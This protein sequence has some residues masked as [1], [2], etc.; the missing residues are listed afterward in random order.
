MSAFFA[1]LDPVFAAALGLAAGLALGLMH[2]ATLRK[3]T[4][5]YLS[6]GSYGRAIA[7]QL[8]RLAL[9]AAALSGLALAGAVPLLSAALGLLIGRA[10]IFRRNRGA[11]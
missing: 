1:S 6:G 5:M 9:L 10:V 11:L 3:V 4:Q 8:A 7:L 2:F